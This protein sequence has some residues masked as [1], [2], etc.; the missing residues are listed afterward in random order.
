[1]C[2]W[3]LQAASTAWFGWLP[4]GNHFGRWALGVGVGIGVNGKAYLRDKTGLQG[5][6]GLLTRPR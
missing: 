1:M 2:G 4:G 6:D 5:R 3:G